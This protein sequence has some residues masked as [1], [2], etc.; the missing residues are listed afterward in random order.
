MNER[1]T[2]ILEA[3]KAVFFRFGVTKTTMGDIAKAAG[4]SRQTLYNA[5]PGKDEVLR[6]SVKAMADGNIAEAQAEWN[7][8]DDF[9]VRLDIFFNRVPLG[10]FNITYQTPDR[11][12]LAEG[13]YAAASGE[14][15]AFAQTWRKMIAAAVAELDTGT[16]KAALADFIFA[17]AY[18]AKHGA[19]D[20]KVIE[21]RLGLLKQSVLALLEQD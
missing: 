20:R 1:D 12:D 4:I 3:A 21:T 11:E 9:A 6:A 13:I 10:W 14:L 17:T 7:A 2:K 5:Y 16:D 18:N 19:K 15:E 8:V